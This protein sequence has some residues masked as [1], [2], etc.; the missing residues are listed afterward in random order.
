MMSGSVA[1]QADDTEVVVGLEAE[2]LHG[3]TRDPPGAQARDL[4]Q[5]PGAGRAH[6]RHALDRLEGSDG[7]VEHA[8]GQFDGA[9]LREV[10]GGLDQVGPGLRAKVGW[11]QHES[12]RAC[13]FNWAARLGVSAW[14]RAGE[15]HG[16]GA[17][18]GEDP[19]GYQWLPS[20]GGLRAAPEVPLAAT[21]LGRQS[22]LTNADCWAASGVFGQS[23]ARPEAIRGRRPTWRPHGCNVTMKR[24]PFPT[25]S[26]DSAS[27]RAGRSRLP[28]E[29]PGTSRTRGPG[30]TKGSA[31][32]IANPLISMAPRPGL[33]PGTYGLTVRRSTD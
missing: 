23:V 2:P 8:L 24:E 21:A 11:L 5:L 26:A 20:L 17:H 27:V 22:A 4:A 18:A 25:R 16:V 19:A 29:T 14:L 31:T 13:F 28:A 7:R 12:P 15:A 9:F 6:R 3:E 10:P 1:E 33:E 30:K 32:C